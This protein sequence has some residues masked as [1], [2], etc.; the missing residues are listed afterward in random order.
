MADSNTKRSSRFVTKKKAEGRIRFGNSYIWP[1][2]KST[3]NLLIEVLENSSEVQQQAI[4]QML[5]EI[6][7]INE[8]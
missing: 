1:E 5:A 8:K 3:L 7:G 2:H 6:K 4:Y